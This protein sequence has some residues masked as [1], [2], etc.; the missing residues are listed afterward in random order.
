MAI[1]SKVFDAAEK[2][3]SSNSGLQQ[4]RLLLHVGNYPCNLIASRVLAGIF[5]RKLRQRLDVLAWLLKNGL[6]RTSHM[7]TSYSCYSE[8]ILSSIVGPASEWKV[9][10]ERF[11]INNYTFARVEVMFITSN[12][13]LPP[14]FSSS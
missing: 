9:G 10:L 1:S 7:L 12:R 5:K 14:A 6:A 11:S 8:F 3:I 4:I 2:P 13:C